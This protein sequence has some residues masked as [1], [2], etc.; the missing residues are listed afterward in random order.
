M[1]KEHLR[2]FTIIELLSS[3]AIFFI[4]MSIGA[5]QVRQI[6]HSIDR[7]TAIKQVEFD[8]RRVRSEALAQGVRFIV[9]WNNDGHTFT[10]GA[11]YVPY[12]DPASYD[13]MFFSSTI[14]SPISLIP[15]PPLMIFDS[16]GFLVDDTGN[17]INA[18]IGFYYNGSQYGASTLSATGELSWSAVGGG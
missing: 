18:T 9:L 8:L 2:G 4:I 11:D 5:P 3:L 15:S 14:Q 17:L 10:A 1:T 7:A 6:L 13:E 16:R 12:N